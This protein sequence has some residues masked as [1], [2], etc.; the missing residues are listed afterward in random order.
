MRIAEEAGKGECCHDSN[1]RKKCPPIPEETESRRSIRGFIG[2]GGEGCVIPPR[3][4][5][6]GRRRRRRKWRRS[7]TEMSPLPSFFFRPLSL[8][9]SKLPSIAST[10]RV[11]SVLLQVW[12][13]AAA[14]TNQ[15]KEE[16]N[17][18]CEGGEAAAIPD[19]ADTPGPLPL[20]HPLPRC[21]CGGRRRGRE[22]GREAAWGSWHYG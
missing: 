5:Y 8:P 20:P 6:R 21:C 12:W 13:R 17:W 10:L 14:P 4:K 15:A 22:R 16:K 3:E 19:L 2:G 7:V 9:T 11:H 18:V 1:H